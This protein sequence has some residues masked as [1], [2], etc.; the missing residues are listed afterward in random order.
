MLRLSA[1]LHR[2]LARLIRG[3]SP[4]RGGYVI[5]NG[6]DLEGGGRGGHVIANGFAAVWLV[7]CDAVH[8][9]WSGRLTWLSVSRSGADGFDVDRFDVDRFAAGGGGMDEWVRMVCDWAGL[10]SKSLC[11]LGG[12]SLTSFRASTKFMKIARI[13]CERKEQQNGQWEATVC[14]S[15]IDWKLYAIAENGHGLVGLRLLVVKLMTS[16]NSKLVYSVNQGFWI[17]VHLV[18]DCAEH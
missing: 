17:V 14:S 2:A 4:A 10:L 13:T 6:F 15:Y 7:D 11:A 1:I 3:V 16:R 18:A 9:P 8:E 5:V 12:M